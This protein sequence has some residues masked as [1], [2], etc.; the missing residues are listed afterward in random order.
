MGVNAYG[1]GLEEDED[2]YFEVYDK[3][4]PILRLL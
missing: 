4:D 2:V 1:S 3:A